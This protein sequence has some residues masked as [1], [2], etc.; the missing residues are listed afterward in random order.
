MNGVRSDCLSTAERLV[1]LF[2]GGHFGP[3]IGLA[4]LLGTS[5]RDIQS[6]KTGLVEA[7]TEP[8]HSRSDAHLPSRALT[9]HTVRVTIAPSL[10][11]TMVA[12]AQRAPAGAGAAT[13]AAAC[14]SG[15]RKKASR[16]IMT[17]TGLVL[18]C[19]LSLLNGSVRSV[20]RVCGR[21]FT[22]SRLDRRPCSTSR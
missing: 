2:I 5:H 15:A 7:N 4:T 22:K 9:T 21:F 18:R 20:L 16:A 14:A 8:P 19:M 13:G 6:P 10:A 3:G 11:R 1:S 17:A 12:D